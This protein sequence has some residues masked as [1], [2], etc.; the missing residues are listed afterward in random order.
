MPHDTTHAA[1]APHAMTP[2]IPELVARDLNPA[3]R[4]K[5][6]RPARP[7]P[8][9]RQ[10]SAND[11]TAAPLTGEPLTRTGKSLTGEPVTGRPLTDPGNRTPD[12]PAPGQPPHAAGS[13]PRPCR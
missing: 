1:T 7:I 2:E 5:V 6:S 3:R 4:K 9:A 13:A 10:H 11:A 12:R 8:P